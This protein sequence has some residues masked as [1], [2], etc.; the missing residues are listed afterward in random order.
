MEKSPPEKRFPEG[1]AEGNQRSGEEK[2]SILRKPMHDRRK[3]RQKTEREPRCQQKSSQAARELPEHEK[4]PAEGRR[5]FRAGSAK[6][7]IFPVSCVA[8]PEKTVYNRVLEILR[9]RGF[10]SNENI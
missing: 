10:E 1:N 4:F 5:F 3:K 2:F 8:R 6:T 7:G 9:I